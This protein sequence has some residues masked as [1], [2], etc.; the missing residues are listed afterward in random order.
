[1]KK[2]MKRNTN[3]L[4]IFLATLALAVWPIGNISSPADAIGGNFVVHGGPLRQAIASATYNPSSNQYMLVWEDNISGQNQAK[5]I[6]LDTNGLPV[7]SSF[8]I[9]PS[10][11]IQTRPVVV[12]NN[13]D[14]EYFVT[15][16]D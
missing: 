8:Y 12:Y 4:L 6:I 5:G 3:I 1:M 11:S 15:W 13:A 7:G 10:D 2:E 9:S 16:K 14:N